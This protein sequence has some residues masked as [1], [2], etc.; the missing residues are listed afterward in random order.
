MFVAE[1]G[2]SSLLSPY[3]VPEKIELV[4][5]TSPVQ[6][7]TDSTN[8]FEFVSSTGV[9]ALKSYRPKHSGNEEGSQE[10]QECEGSKSVRPTG[11][12]IHKALKAMLFDVDI[13]FETADES[14]RIV[15][16][17]VEDLVARVVESCKGQELGSGK[18]E[19]AT[20]EMLEEEDVIEEEK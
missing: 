2:E 6:V 14:A 8:P 5:N 13:K 3:P 20:L 10:Y 16:P 12:A 11:K 1:V 9:D 17:I 18:E 7:V 4:R 15:R 19:E